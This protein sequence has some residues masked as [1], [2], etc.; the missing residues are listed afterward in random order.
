MVELCQTRDGVSNAGER[1]ACVPADERMDSNRRVV[2][3]TA[4]RLPQSREKK[5]NLL[6]PLVI[7]ASSETVASPATAM[8]TLIFC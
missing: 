8:R 7:P 1:Q 2:A 6:S 4:G 3:P 5:P